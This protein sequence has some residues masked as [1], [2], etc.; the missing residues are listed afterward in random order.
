M[1]YRFGFF[2]RARLSQPNSL[3]VSKRFDNCNWCFGEPI[4]LEN[5]VFAGFRMDTLYCNIPS[6]QECFRQLVTSKEHKAAL[7]HSVWLTLTLQLMRAWLC[8]DHVNRHRLPTAKVCSEDLYCCKY[9]RTSL[10]ITALHILYY[11]FLLLHIH[12]YTDI[13]TRDLYYR[14]RS[15]L[16]IA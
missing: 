2:Q 16:R 13:N 6:I 4:I 9:H 1:L 8:D 12:Y 11:F 5:W 3:L 15:M 14:I 10:R 7:W